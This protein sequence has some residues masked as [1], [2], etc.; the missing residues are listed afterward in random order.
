MSSSPTPA[1]YVVSVSNVVGGTVSQPATLAVLRKTPVVTWSNAAP[2]TYGA[3]LN[4]A[5]L[6]ATA[7]VPGTF[8]YNPPAG[9][10]LDAGSYLL[11]VVFTPTDTVDYNSVTQYASLTVSTAPLTVTAANAAA[12]L[13][14]G[15]PGF[16][17]NGHWI[18]RIGQHHGGLL[19]RRRS[20]QPAG[21][22]SHRALVG[23]S[24]WPAGQLFGHAQQRHA[25]G[26]RRRAA[27]DFDR[28]A[29][30]RFDQRQPDGDPDRHELRD[31]RERQ[32]WLGAGDIRECGQSDDADVADTGIGARRGQRDHQ[33]SGRESGEPAERFHIRHS[34]EHP[35][36]AV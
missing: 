36:S 34:A 1:A 30:H 35:D 22:L 27:D 32:L 6:N 23:G 8:A 11:S 25:D 17:G 10:V 13:R 14:P 2:I 33:Q 28:P 15:E 19:L 29:R 24:V 18:A 31:R 16:H 21:R 26:E 5:Q 7:S 20:G 12:R 4:N 3:A 9:T